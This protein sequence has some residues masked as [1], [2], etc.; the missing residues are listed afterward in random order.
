MDT[1]K[2]VNFQIGGALTISPHSSIDNMMQQFQSLLKNLENQT[3][4]HQ[5]PVHINHFKIEFLSDNQLLAQHLEQ[6]VLTSYNLKTITTKNK[7]Y[8]LNFD[9][10]CIFEKEDDYFVIKNDMLDLIGTGLTEIA[11]KES[12]CQEFDFIYQRY[13]Q[14]EDNKLSNR[15]LNIKKLSIF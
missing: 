7:R 11:A 4:L 10:L 13:N 3:P 5:Y 1:S 15:I 2:S 8:E 6:D 12:F 9:L 14:L